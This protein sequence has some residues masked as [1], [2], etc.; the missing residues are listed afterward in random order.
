MGRHGYSDDL[1]QRQLAMWRGRVMSSIRGKRGQKML[2][3]LRDALDAMPEKRLVSRTL[4]DT[5]GGVCALGCLSRSMGRD[6]V[7]YVGVED[8]D[9]VELNGEL[10]T[11]FDVAECLVQEV[12]FR[13]D[14]GSPYGG[15]TSEQRWKRM[16]QWVDK[17]ISAPQ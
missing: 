1:D 6:F 12:E 4:Q 2:H 7:E 3:D 5:R 14:E 15:E 16:R 13:N 8:D 9:M 10:A 11:L 17:N